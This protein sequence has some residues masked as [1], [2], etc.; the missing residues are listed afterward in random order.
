MFEN[1]Q[2]INE[3]SRV[4]GLKEENMRQL[5]K[6]QE[7]KMQASS[8]SAADVVDE[9]P[10]Q[11][12]TVIVETPQEE[13]LSVTTTPEKPAQ[14]ISS[15]VPSQPNIF[16]QA[17]PSFEQNVV[18]PQVEQVAP[19]PPQM[20]NEEIPAYS[21]VSVLNEVPIPGQEE[22][23]TNLD[24]PQ[25]FFD[26]VEKSEE[27]NL[28][29]LSYEEDPALLLVGNLK[30]LIE[31]KNQMIQAL[32]DKVLVLEEQLR[33]SEESRKVFEA[34]KNAAESTLQAARS[35]EANG[36]PTLVYQQQNYQQA[37]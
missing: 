19:I 36:G 24:T 8:F 25:T 18:T 14:V 28:D 37:A 10:V 34:Q 27:T 6:A 23:P 22:V 30:K 26:R 21:N 35:A 5:I 3:G 11:E 9:I 4:I 16:D 12:Q 31:D 29:A 33:V 7:E 2:I 32:N 13:A 17:M 1:A 15:E 20:H